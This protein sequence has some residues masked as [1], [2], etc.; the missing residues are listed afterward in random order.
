MV[1]LFLANPPGGPDA[2]HCIIAPGGYEFWRVDAAD[3][4]R[5]IEVSVG[6]FH[7][8][9]SL[10]A[11]LRRYRQYRRKPTANAP[12][13]PTDFPAVEIKVGSANRTG[14]TELQVLPAG[15]L[16]A[17]SER[18]DISAGL[19]SL[20]RNTDRSLELRLAHPRCQ[21]ELIFVPQLTAK[22]PAVRSENN[23]FAFDADPE[24]VVRGTI[25]LTPTV[26]TL[27][28]TIPFNGKGSHQHRWRTEG[29]P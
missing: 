15:S 25:Q 9:P 7:G 19:H 4:I 16:R 24:C 10:P 2:S 27:V 3:D 14:V 6:F 21:A 11:Y 28:I 17:S 18:L 5:Q 29:S 22:P 8:H 12:P 1:P 23:E 20:R 13:T 26:G